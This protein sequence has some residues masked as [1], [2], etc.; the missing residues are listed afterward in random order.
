MKRS[1]IF[2]GIAGVLVLVMVGRNLVADLPQ[3]KEVVRLGRDHTLGGVIL[4]PGTY[5]V[6]HKELG[7]REGTE[8]C[9]FV[10]RGTSVSEKNLM[11]Q[12][13]CRRS[14]GP[15]VKQFTIEST[16]QP[17]GAFLVRSLQFSGSTDIH[18]YDNGAH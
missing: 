11:I 18:N 1:N 2:L 16:R 5:L 4:K 15:A 14:Q 6:V 17:D 12:A 7:G 9:T 13:I 8:P 3:S 10:Y